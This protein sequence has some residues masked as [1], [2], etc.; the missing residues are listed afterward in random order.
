[1]IDQST[2][3]KH[4]CN[5]AYKRNSQGQ[6]PGREAIAEVFEL[7][8][9]RRLFVSLFHAKPSQLHTLFPFNDGIGNPSTAG[10]GIVLAS[11]NENKT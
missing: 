1:M 8:Y 4:A 11:A 5:V 3:A 2:E 6:V 10:P 7:Q 9:K